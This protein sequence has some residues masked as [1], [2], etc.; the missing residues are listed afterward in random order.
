MFL[1]N[2]P[3]AMFIP[4]AT[5]IPESRVH[6]S[7][8]GVGIIRNAGIIRGWAL[9]EEIR[10]IYNYLETKQN[11]CRVLLALRRLHFY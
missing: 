10:Y 8:S 6:K 1:P 2:V 3:G 11:T 5:F 4:G 9:Y 7:V